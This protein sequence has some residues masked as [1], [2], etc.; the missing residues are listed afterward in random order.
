MLRFVIMLALFV[1]SAA[2]QGVDDAKYTEEEGMVMR[3][4]DADNLDVSC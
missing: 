1:Y 2:G 3:Q 4:A